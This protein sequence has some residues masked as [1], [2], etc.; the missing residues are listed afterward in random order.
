MNSIVAIEWGGRVT[1]QR[2]AVELSNARFLGATRSGVATSFVESADAA[3][4]SRHDEAA[5]DALMSTV[6]GRR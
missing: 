6:V 1:L 2:P 3:A 5:P 4:S